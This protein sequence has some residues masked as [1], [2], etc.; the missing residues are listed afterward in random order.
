MVLKGARMVLGTLEGPDRRRF[1]VETERYWRRALER[2]TEQR[3]HFVVT[4]ML[5]DSRES[6]LDIVRALRHSTGCV[7]I[8]VT[9]HSS[10]PNCVE[11]MRAGAW[12][13]IEKSSDEVM[14]SD[15][16]HRLIESMQAAWTHIRSHPDARRLPGDNQ[17][18]QDNYQALA[19]E[20]PGEVVAV[21][22]RKVV[23]HDRSFTKLSIRLEADYPM[24]RPSV[25]SIPELDQGETG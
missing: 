4:D 10:I 18:I 15:V 8:V 11:A 13:Y 1:E 7:V 9:A 2:L 20:F 22:G 3:F 6:G 12:D 16:F 14:S 21:L 25:V 24:T 5:M 23:D 17:W 19:S